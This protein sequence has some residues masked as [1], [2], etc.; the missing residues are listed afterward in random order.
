MGGIVAMEQSLKTLGVLALPYVPYLNHPG[1]SQRV[2]LA[3][4]VY[5]TC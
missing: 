3:W 4:T 5:L 1:L 2:D